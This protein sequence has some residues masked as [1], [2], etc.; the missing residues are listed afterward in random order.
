[1]SRPESDGVGQSPK[2]EG[3]STLLRVPIPTLTSN[4]ILPATLSNSHD[5]D[6]LVCTA[7]RTMPCSYFQAYT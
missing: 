7:G 3:H 4:P 5:P 6:P 2:T 1:M